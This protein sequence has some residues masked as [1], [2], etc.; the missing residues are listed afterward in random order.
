MFR[1][2]A[3]FIMRTFNLPCVVCAI[4]GAVD[5]AVVGLVVGA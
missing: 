1:C 5:V 2:V 3:I 4:V